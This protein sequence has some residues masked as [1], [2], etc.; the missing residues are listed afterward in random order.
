MFYLSS[1][2]AFISYHKFPSGGGAWAQASP[3]ISPWLI[4]FFISS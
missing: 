2:D 3:L 4:E 1:F